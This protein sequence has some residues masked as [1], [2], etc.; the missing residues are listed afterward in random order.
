MQNIFNHSFIYKI[1]ENT[2]I[3]MIENS[4]WFVLLCIISFYKTIFY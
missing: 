3:L 2:F 4:T 1:N